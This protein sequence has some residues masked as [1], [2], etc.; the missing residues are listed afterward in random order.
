[1]IDSFKRI[2]KT[3]RDLSMIAAEIWLIYQY[4]TIEW[5]RRYIARAFCSF[6]KKWAPMFSTFFILDTIFEIDIENQKNYKI[7]NVVFILVFLSLW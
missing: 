1:M 4:R 7:L 2:E 3:D 5:A 6:A